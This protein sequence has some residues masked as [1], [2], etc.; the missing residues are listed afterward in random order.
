MTIEYVLQGTRG[1]AENA[2]PLILEESEDLKIAV[3]GL[4]EDSRY[5]L[6]LNGKN[7]ELCNGSASIPKARLKKGVLRP[8][9]YEFTSLGALSGKYFLT[10]F[11]VVSMLT[12]IN[13]KLV[14]YPETDDILVRLMKLE[15]KTE[16]Q[17]Q[18]IRELTDIC[19]ELT[20]AQSRF[21]ERMTKAEENLVQI[22]KHLED[23]LGGR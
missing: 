17:E 10:P 22:N 7:T 1:V 16:R 2:S 13:D 19:A 6:S 5:L 14:A 23:P 15:Q 9:L 20:A 8:E 12:Q 11:S 4:K 21:E 3:K 18:T